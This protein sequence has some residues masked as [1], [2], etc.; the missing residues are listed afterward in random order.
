M[1]TNDHFF[2][3]LPSDSSTEYYPENTTSCYTTKLPREISLQGKWEVALQE[4]CIPL[5]FLNFSNNERV[6]LYFYN[7]ILDRKKVDKDFHQT[8]PPKSYVDLKSL[9]SDLNVFFETRHIAINI[10]P[11]EFV[12]IVTTCKAC[13]Y[14]HEIRM[15]NTM[16]SV[17]G[18]KDSEKIVL[19]T[20][21]RIQ[22]IYPGDIMNSLPREAFIYASV[23]E[24]H[25]VGNVQTPLLR[26]FPLRYRK[27]KFGDL[28]N[29][30]FG[31]PN[32]IPI[33]TN[34]FRTIEID[35]RDRFGNNLPFENG[36]STAT[37][38][39]RRTA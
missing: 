33:L 14:Y 4:M 35:I 7:L 3:I 29:M 31:T 10:L 2:I 22:G 38:H 20:E 27:G 6:S 26:S 32:Y 39:F 24:P 13:D 11:N 25:I 36:L 9:V 28:Q 12:E 15:S 8:F 5:A 17:L 37:L 30:V 16:L 1:N 23:C 18:F 21:S 19:Q 34:S